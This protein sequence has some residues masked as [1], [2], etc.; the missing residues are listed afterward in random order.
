M[1]KI[2]RTK[3]M[4][5]LPVGFAPGP[6]HVICAKGKAPKQHQ[7]NKLLRHL[8][9]SKM[10]DYANSKEKLDRSYIVSQ[11]IK[12]IRQEG[13]F[14]RHV[15][16]HWFDVGD[17]NAREKIGQIFRDGLHTKFKS[18]TKSKASMRRRRGSLM[19]LCSSGNSSSGEESAN[20]EPLSIEPLPFQPRPVESSFPIQVAFPK[21]AK[22]QMHGFCMQKQ[23]D[24]EPLPLSRAVSINFNSPI[25]VSNECTFDESMKD[26]LESSQPAE[27]DF[28]LNEATL[29]MLEA[30]DASS[31]DFTL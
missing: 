4:I 7:G 16:G 3:E 17:R 22:F 19:S 5:P 30:S 25:G 24:F 11:I 1:P 13:G 9:Q 10:Q 20:F 29:E 15:D 28:S 27:L 18:S 8:I 31:F 12:T 6:S 14:V 2:S 21:Q 23:L 26:F